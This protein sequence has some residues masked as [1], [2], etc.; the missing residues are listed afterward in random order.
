MS[1][2]KLTAVID[3]K[4]Q[5]SDKIKKM[6]PNFKAAFAAV[7]AGAAAA[8]AAVGAFAIKSIKDFSEIG[9][10]VEKMS[11]RTGLSAE[12]VSAL[13]VA[14]DGAGTSIQ[15][16]EAAVKKMQLN[17]ETAEDGTS[18]LGEAVTNLGL[19]FDDIRG[20]KPEDQFSAIGNAIAHIEDPATRTQAAF[21]AF[22]KAGTELIPLFDEGSFS[23]AEWSEEAK[24]LGVSFDDVSANKAAQLNDALGRM[25]AAMQGVTLQVGGFLAPA[26]TAF[27]NDAVVPALPAL[28]SLMVNGFEG[29]SR[30]VAFLRDKIKELW[31]WL[32]QIGIIDSFRDAFARLEEVYRTQLLP[33]LQ[34]LWEAL[35]PLMPLLEALAGVLGTLVV[36]ALLL[37]INALT[38]VVQ[39]LA[40]FV[41]AFAEATEMFMTQAA[42]AISF[43]TDTLNAF[44][45]G[46]NMTFTAI[47]KVTEAITGLIRKFKEASSMG[48]GGISS[49]ISNVFK[50]ARA[51]GGPV[52]SGGAY[53][54]G[55]R[56]PEMFVPNQ[57][58]TII[59]NG[60]GVVVHVN[61]GS[62]SSSIDVRNMAEQVGKALMRTLKLNQ[63][64]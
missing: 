64:I 25:K 26:V 8:A 32:E 7:A 11:A 19:S 38:I 40:T 4:D 58:G 62:V 57:N 60:G 36:G 5:A 31:A 61:V 34:Q 63:Q 33:A 39:W 48:I 1:E 28:Q 59:P 37:L 46:L 51:S 22:G 49:K 29:L 20:M 42:P 2:M 41:Q 27:V 55:E 50:G 17:M 44:R 45:D 52:S 12:A 43:M 10:A 18:K 6:G 53:L 21:E 16:V 13:R 54:V 30:A 9:D 24:R 23:M 14:A 15:T 3:A 35:Q 56:G 47:N